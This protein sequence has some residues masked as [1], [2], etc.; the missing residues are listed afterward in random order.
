MTTAVTMT[1]TRVRRDLVHRANEAEILVSPP[2]RAAEGEYGS[3]TVTTGIS[4]YY[5]DHVG[6][7]RL[8]VLLLIEAG[9][10]A[11][12]SAAHEFEGLSSDIAFFFNS[13]DVA[14]TDP[15][16]LASG[17]GELTIETAFDELRLRRDG[18]PKQVRYTQRGTDTSGRM[19]LRTS[20]AV[21]GVP[22]GS[23]EELRAYQREGSTAPTTAGLRSG[24]RSGPARRA[25]LIPAGDVA[26]TQATNVVLADL[27]TEA[28]GVTA[29]LA[30]DFANPGLFDHDYDHYPAM[31]LIEAG[32]QLA[33]A[34][35]QR[36][37]DQVVTGV[38]ATFGHFAELDRE[39]RIVARHGE[40]WTDMECVQD[41]V[42][43]TR[44]SFQLAPAGPHG[45][46]AP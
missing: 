20:M 34:S 10:Q 17:E 22:K 6:T 33:L 32:R 46:D 44:M 40:R 43:V 39:T 2:W 45:G 3:T 37:T 21:Q 14:I 9:R 27:R 1:N 13:I 7:R 25:D 24:L 11:A 18:T 36:V 30:P 8:D 31:V 19:V 41:G 35:A 23:Y 42:A 38:R 26:R 28:S 5:L 15:A 29:A 4:P 16:A 12:L